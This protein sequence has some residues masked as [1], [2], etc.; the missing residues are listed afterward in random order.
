MEFSILFIIAFAIDLVF[1]ELDYPFHPIRLMGHFITGFQKL[2]RKESDSPRVEQVKG[3]LMWAGLVALTG[4][5]VLFLL[6]I[7]KPFA[8]IIRI[9]LIYSVI[10]V[11]S[12][13]N[14]AMKVYK[15]LK[16][17]DLEE[18]RFKLSYIV[19]RDT[20]QLSED[21]VL[22]ASI[23]TVSE[24]TS[25]GSI[26]PM[27]YLLIGGPLAAFIYKS[28]NT[29]DSM[30]GY[31]NDKY[32]NFGRFPAKLDDVANYI[33]ARITALYLLLASSLL[34]MNSGNG[35]RVMKRDANKHKSPNAGYPESVTAGCLEI[36]LG[37]DGLY[38]GKRIEK[39]SL[40][41]PIRPVKAEDIVASCKMLYVSSIFFALSV[42]M[43]RLLW[44][45]IL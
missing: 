34:Q 24:N 4:V 45:F 15:P 10:S 28:I 44:Y 31:K 42:V 32:L 38:F 23:E 14:E 20:K 41:D 33:P 35:Y 25:D 21:E 7:P 26:A 11:G 30:V 12:L 9:Y 13:K 18:A 1:G 22:K 8:Y 36:E 17:K 6:M 43:V 37:G 29:M 5:I 39:A 2:I 19:G 27:F 16:N 3:L 40:G